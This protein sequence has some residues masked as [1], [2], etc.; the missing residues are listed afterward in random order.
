MPTASDT[1]S[2]SIPNSFSSYEEYQKI[3]EFHQIK[4]ISASLKSAYQ[5]LAKNFS[6]QPHKPVVLHPVEYVSQAGFTLFEI[7]ERNPSDHSF[8][9]DLALGRNNLVIISLE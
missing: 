7:K 2:P 1:D 3:F 4:E 9:A 5:A 6:T 8:I